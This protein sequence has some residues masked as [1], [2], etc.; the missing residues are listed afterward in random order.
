MV[1]HYAA[2]GTCNKKIIIALQ[3][4]FYSFTA[5]KKNIEAH[6][7]AKNDIDPVKVY[8]DHLLKRLLKK[9][10]KSTVKNT[11]YHLFLY[12]KEKNN[13]SGEKKKTSSRFEAPHFFTIAIIK[14]KKICFKQQFN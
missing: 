3:K 11:R 13:E 4:P 5:R 1:Q 7:P 12:L 2:E 14:R 6:A 9:C 8:D 10:S